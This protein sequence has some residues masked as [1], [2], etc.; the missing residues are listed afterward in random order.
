MSLMIHV[1]CFSNYT[2]HLEYMSIYF[3]NESKLLN[4]VGVIGNKRQR[5][6]TKFDFSS[7]F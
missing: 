2:S 4:L 5:T 3:K 1:F 7:T 6:D